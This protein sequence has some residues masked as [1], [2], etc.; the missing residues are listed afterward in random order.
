MPDIVKMVK[1]IVKASLPH[2]VVMRIRRHRDRN[3]LGRIGVE[4]SAHNPD[5][6]YFGTEY[7]GY[8]VPVS[9]VEDGPVWSFGAGEDISFE[10]MIARQFATNV[11]IFDPTPRAISYCNQMLNQEHNL[12]GRMYFFPFGIWTE[13]GTMRFFAPKNKDHVSHSIVNLQHTRDYF[14]AECLSPLDILERTGSESPAIVKLNI[15]GAEY[16]VMRAIFGSALDPKIICITFDEL[17]T[18]ID[19]ASDK[20]MTELA[21]RFRQEGYEVIHT[22]GCKVTY[23]RSTA[24][25]NEIRHESRYPDSGR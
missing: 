12:L 20:R 11:Y 8:A 17:H 4:V 23:A 16:E 18:A 14:E 19:G 3:R 25:R 7:G 21:S 22:V 15:E 5:V 10:L 24:L 2:F 1:S 9:M 13:T 6:K